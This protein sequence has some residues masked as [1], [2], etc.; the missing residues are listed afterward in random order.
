LGPSKPIFFLSFF[1]LNICMRP[2]ANAR[3]YTRCIEFIFFFQTLHIF[4]TFFLYFLFLSFF[5]FSPAMLRA[6]LT[7]TLAAGLPSVHARPAQAAAD[8]ALLLRASPAPPSAPVRGRAAPLRPPVSAAGLP[9][10]GA[11]RPHAVAGAREPL[12]EVL[13]GHMRGN[14]ERA[15][16]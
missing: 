6:V 13:P 7:R 3:D 12:P 11:T 4:F 1:F 16:G 8:Q 2:L 15:C 9:V 14:G 5:P 10:L